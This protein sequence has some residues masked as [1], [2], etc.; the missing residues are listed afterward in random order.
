M[1]CPEVTGE[2]SRPTIQV[3]NTL[4][5]EISAVLLVIS[6]SYILPTM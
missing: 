1:R 4:E 2:Q 5:P 6:F 3:G